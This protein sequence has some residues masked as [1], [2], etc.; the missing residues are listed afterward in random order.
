MFYNLGDRKLWGDEAETALLAVSVMKHG[1]PVCTDGK[2][3]VTLY[4]QTV[5][6]NEKNVWI[7]RPWLDQYISAAAFFLFGVSTASAR[8]P[9]AIAGVLCVLIFARLVYKVYESHEMAVIAALC[10]VTSEMFILH[11][12]QCRYYS[13]VVLAEIWL[14]IG[15]YNLFSGRPKRGAIHVALALAAAFYCNYIIV[16]GNTIAVVFTAILVHDRYKH[17]WRYVIAGFAAFALMA[18]P[19]IL[20]AQPWHQAGQ[21][22]GNLYIP[23]LHYYAVEINFHM[24]PFALLLIPAGYF[25]L[26]RLSGG[27]LPEKTPAQ[28][29]LELFLWIVIPIQLVIISAVPGLFVRYFVPLIPVFCILQAVLLIRYIRGRLPRYVLVL[30]LCFTNVLSIF[31]LYF[32]RYGHKP[33]SPIIN[34]VRCITSPYVGRLDDVIEFLKREA[35]PGQSILVYDSEFPLIFY[36]NMQVID[37]RFTA[38]KTVRPDWFFPIGPSCVFDMKPDSIPDYLAADFTP[39]EIEVHRSKRAGS[40]PDPDKYEYFSTGDKERFVIYK[41]NTG[42]K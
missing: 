28:A 2:N 42:A 35:T 38:G 11:V 25:I 22:S 16:I 37:G 10:L 7:W 31:G 20:Y 8:L 40:I 15:L 33:A 32:F 39:L 26:R 19:W 12:R 1:L 14:I 17:L 24:F 9:F 18:A 23:K 41:R 13:I 27:N 30:L 5:D 36:T 4:G 29:D 34:L 6:S 3:T 21:L